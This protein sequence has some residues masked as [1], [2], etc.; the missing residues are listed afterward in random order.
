MK[1]KAIVVSEL[2][3]NKSDCAQL[4]EDKAGHKGIVLSEYEAGNIRMLLETMRELQFPVNSG[5]WFDFV[6]LRI[7]VTWHSN[8]NLDGYLKQIYRHLKNY[9]E[10]ENV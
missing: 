8:V 6:R 3:L 7:P 9:F 10:K 5:D 4:I 2:D 1:Q